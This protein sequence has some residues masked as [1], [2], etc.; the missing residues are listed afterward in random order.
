MKLANAAVV[1]LVVLGTFGSLVAIQ[2]IGVSRMSHGDSELRV[3]ICSPWWYRSDEFGCNFSPLG[4]HLTDCVKITEKGVLT[5]VGNIRT[6]CKTEQF[7][8]DFWGNEYGWTRNLVGISCPGQDRRRYQCVKLTWVEDGVEKTDC[9][10]APSDN[11]IA[12]PCP[13]ADYDT[14]RSC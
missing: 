14:L 8:S 1:G 13:T 7:V 12:D 3:G 2:I 9:G 6:S 11:G 5:C 4:S 10:R